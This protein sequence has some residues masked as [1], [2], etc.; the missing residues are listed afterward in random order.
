MPTAYIDNNILGQEPNWPSITALHA[1]KPDARIVI[2]DWQMVELAGVSDR[3]QALQ[4]ADFVDSLKPLW[5]IGYL[6][7]QQ[8]EAKRFTWCHYYRVPA[9]NF[10]VFTEHLSVVWSYYLG[11]NTPLT[12]I[13]ARRWVDLNKDLSGI[14]SE[15]NQT[16]DALNTLR[17]A[18]AKQKKEVEHQTF[19]DWLQPRIDNRD[20]DGRAITKAKK[21]EIAEFCYTNHEKFYA[22]C[23][24]IA[25][26]SELHRIRSQDPNR[27]P[28]ASDAIDLFHGVLGLS[29]CDLYVTADR[30]AHQC[31]TQAKKALPSLRTAAIVKSM[32]DL[33]AIV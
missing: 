31:A 8:H 4:R 22:D 12:G 32:S 20:P 13:N 33:A 15:K 16:I 21:I 28:R 25:V 24:A 6:P 19:L 30:F 9:T 29:Y 5:M 18:T 14:N 23:P 1:A 11:P 2:S 7:I 26:E 3:V 10:E 27:P 17:A